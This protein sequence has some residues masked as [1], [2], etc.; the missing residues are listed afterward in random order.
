[1]QVIPDEDMI[2]RQNAVI[3]SN[4]KKWLRFDEKL[5]ICAMPHRP[6]IYHHSKMLWKYY[7]S[8]TQFKSNHT[9]RTLTETTSPWHWYQCLVTNTSQDHQTTQT[10]NLENSVDINMTSCMFR[11]VRGWRFFIFSTGRRHGRQ[12]IFKHSAQ[13]ASCF[14]QTFTW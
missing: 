8:I 9:C 13:S 7:H 5:H 11:L 1:M 6:Q 2:S 12:L 3:F 10:V 4:L 14:V